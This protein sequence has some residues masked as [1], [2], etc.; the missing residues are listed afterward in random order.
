MSQVDRED[1]LSPL[2]QEEDHHEGEGVGRDASLGLTVD[3]A[4][5]SE[6]TET[7]SGMKTQRNTGITTQKYTQGLEHRYTKGL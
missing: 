1:G 5:L 6:N 4:Q 7:H 2:L 3:V